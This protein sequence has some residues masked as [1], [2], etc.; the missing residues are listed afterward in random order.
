[1]VHF[2]QHFQPIMK[3]STLMHI[4]N[5]HGF[6]YNRLVPNLKTADWFSHNSSSSLF[7]YGRAM[8]KRVSRHMRTA[9][10]LLSLRICADW[11][12]PSLS[13]HKITGY[14]RIMNGEQRP[15]WYFAHAQ[16]N[17]NMRILHMLEGIFFFSLDAVNILEMFV[18]TL[19]VRVLNL[20]NA[21]W[22]L[23]QSTCRFQLW[24]LLFP[25]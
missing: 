19:P 5:R 2:Y 22:Y 25:L 15:G 3:N 1:M 23:D 10:A 17:L 20:L 9:K 6:F 7:A 13:A 4:T 8:P 14:Y 18:P 24:V 21:T 16:N 11:S 12:G